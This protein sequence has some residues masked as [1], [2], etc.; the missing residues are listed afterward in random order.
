MNKEVLLV[1]MVVGQYTQIVSLIKEARI[2]SGI[3]GACHLLTILKFYS[4]VKSLILPFT[5]VGNNSHIG[6]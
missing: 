5:S 1:E 6:S 2:G 4:F 3:D